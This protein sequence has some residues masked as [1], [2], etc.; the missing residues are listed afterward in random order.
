[1]KEYCR[2]GA[3]GFYQRSREGKEAMCGV[4]GTLTDALEAFNHYR[5][6][7]GTRRLREK[8]ELMIL[9][10]QVDVGVTG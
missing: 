10:H 5:K 1:M 6:R 9:G 8:C 7:V 3:A 4:P 2:Y